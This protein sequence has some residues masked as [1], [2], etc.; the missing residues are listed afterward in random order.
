MKRRNHSMEQIVDSCDNRKVSYA[1]KLELL[2]IRK[3]KS[4]S[5]NF[6]KLFRKSTSYKNFDKNY[7]QEY[8][9]TENQKKENLRQLKVAEDLNF[10]PS[11]Y[12]EYAKLVNP[13]REY[14]NSLSPEKTKGMGKDSP[15]KIEKMIRE[16]YM[17]YKQDTIHL[18]KKNYFRI[19]KAK[20]SLSVARQLSCKFDKLSFHNKS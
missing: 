14:I 11:D 1:L 15:S 3:Q 5:T 6:P 4:N 18:F 20:E 19:K 7:V 2:S 12:N 9:T 16:D 10:A 8:K 13:R 17:N